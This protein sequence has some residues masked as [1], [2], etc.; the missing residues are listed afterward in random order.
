MTFYNKNLTSIEYNY[1]IYDKKLLAIIRYL[2][3][4]RPKLEYT[5][6]SIK[7]FT[8][9]KN[10]IYFAKKRDLSRRQTRYLNILSKFNIKI[11]YQPDPQNIKTDALTRMTEFKPNSPNNERLQHQHQT[12]LTSNRLKLDDINLSIYNIIKPIFHIVATANIINDFYSEIRNAIAKSQN[13]HY[14]VNLTKCSIRNDILYHK[15]R[16]WISLNLY[17]DVIRETYD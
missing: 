11:I 3:H 4:W 12:I 14:S 7:I 15:N 5:K 6:I 8:N 9:H 13:K 10:L 2:E 17:A 1:Q 16:L